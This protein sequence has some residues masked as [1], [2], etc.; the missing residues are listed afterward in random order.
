MPAKSNTKKEPSMAWKSLGVQG[1]H[2]HIHDQLFTANQ[3]LV[4]NVWVMM[5]KESWIMCFLFG[6]VPAWFCH[7]QLMAKNYY[8]RL[9]SLFWTAAWIQLAFVFSLASTSS[10]DIFWNQCH[11]STR[12]LIHF[13][14]W[15]LIGRPISWVDLPSWG[16]AP[17]SRCP[18]LLGVRLPAK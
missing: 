3:V 8:L 5:M 2:I 10:N 17:V 16:S 12:E 4:F 11:S 1:N 15:I 9:A 6:G 13:V 18:C 7:S 14:V